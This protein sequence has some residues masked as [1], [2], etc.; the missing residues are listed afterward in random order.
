MLFCEFRRPN[1]YEIEALLRESLTST[2][3]SFVQTNISPRPSV[4]YSKAYLKGQCHEI[5][6]SVFLNQTTYPNP[7]KHAQKGF[8]ICFPN[9]QGVIAFITESPVMNRYTGESTQNW[10]SKKLLVQNTPWRQV[11]PVRNT[12]GIPYYLVYLSLEFFL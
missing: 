1:C 2:L 6:P 7:I 11:S 5:F 8:Q 9:I 10:F 3:T 12:L 4:S